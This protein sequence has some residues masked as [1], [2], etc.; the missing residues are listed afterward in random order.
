MIVFSHCTSISL[1]VNDSLTSEMKN[2]SYEREASTLA[3]KRLEQETDSKKAALSQAMSILWG[4]KASSMT[5]LKLN[6]PD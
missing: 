3:V 1:K 2:V 6:L 5:S 4:E